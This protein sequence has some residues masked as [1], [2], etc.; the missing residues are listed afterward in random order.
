MVAGEFL[1]LT[2]YIVSEYYRNN[3]EPFFEYIDENI[4][5]IGPADKQLLRSKDA[6]IEA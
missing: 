2:Y 4:L 6:I 5:W 3:L 1:K